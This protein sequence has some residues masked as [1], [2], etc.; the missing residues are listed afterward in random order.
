VADWAVGY[1]SVHTVNCGPGLD[2]Q[3]YEIAGWCKSHG[4]QLVTTQ[5]EVIRAGKPVERR[6]GLIRA[7]MALKDKEASIEEFISE[8]CMRGICPK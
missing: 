5:G 7:L 6:A 8:K 4:Y 1:V 2:D 3:H